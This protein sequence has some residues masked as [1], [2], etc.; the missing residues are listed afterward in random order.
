MNM[1]RTKGDLSFN[2][3]KMNI[4]ILI[5]KP[6][7][8]AAEHR[9]SIR[10][11]VNG[12]LLAQ[13]ILFA[14]YNDRCT[15]E[16]ISLQIGVAVPYLEKDLKNLCAKGLLI[17]KGGKYETDIVI[18][19]KEFSEESD[20]KTLPVH[21][22]IAKIL[23][24]YLNENLD[25]IKAVGFYRGVEDDNLL[26]WHITQIL[27]NESGTKYAYS[28]NYIFPTKY[29]GIEAI[30]FGT[31]YYSGNKGWMANIEK[32]NVNGDKITIHDFSI[33]N[34]RDCL[35]FDRYQNRINIILDIAE[36]R[37]TGFSEN[38]MSEIAEFIKF[39]FVVKNGDELSLKLPVFTKEQF[40]KIKT[41]IGDVTDVVAEKMREAVN[42]ATNILVQHTPVSMKKD[43]ENIGW[44]QA[45]NCGF[46]S[47]KIMMDNGMLQRVANNTHPTAYVVLAQ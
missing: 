6:D 21:R 34:T 45:R 42:I 4:G 36:G 8:S 10:D 37:N 24:K 15:A 12:N 7:S 17:N 47:V 5:P 41:L 35:Y 13:N 30:V 27:L 14:C 38:D 22:E 23:D 1:E 46:M 31:E 43:A 20:E 33:I 18:L 26:K 29:A 3:G 44:I 11:S 2:P 39:G 25:N 32:S 19:T 40:Y 9:Y 28:L 16:E